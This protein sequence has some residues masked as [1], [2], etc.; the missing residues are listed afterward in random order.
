[1]IIITTLIYLSLS[2]LFLGVIDPLCFDFEAVCTDQ[3]DRARIPAANQIIQYGSFSQP[4]PYTDFPP[5]S[6]IFIA[7][8]RYLGSTDFTQTIYLQ[9]IAL[10][11]TGWLTKKILE[12]DLPKFGILGLVLVLFNPNL[13]SAAYTTYAET[14]Q[15]LFIVI[16]MYFLYRYCFD[17]S[18]KSA[19]A[20]GLFLAAATYVR[21]ITQYLVVLLPVIF[22]LIGLLCVDRINVS[23]T[24]VS[25]ILAT[26]VAVVCMLPWL[27]HMNSHGEG[28]RMYKQSSEPRYIVDI[29]RNLTPSMPGETN[30]LYKQEFYVDQEKR[31]STTVP[32]WESLS[33]HQKLNYQTKDGYLQLFN[34]VVSEPKVT[35]IAITKSTLRFFALGGTGKMFSLLYAN[36]V[37]QV[38]E[39][40]VQ[41][42]LK[43]SAHFEWRAQQESYFKSRPIYWPIK[44][45]FVGFAI[46][47][48]ILGLLGVI[49][50]IKRKRF[51]LLFVV[52]GVIVYVWATHFLVSHPRF[53]I[54][55]ESA[56]TVL[57]VYGIAY[58]NA[59]LKMFRTPKEKT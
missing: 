19:V 14:F 38:K 5:G 25:G 2:I 31:L 59:I 37:D 23:K 43:P 28:W 57:A 56:L 1:M 8:T 7:A 48:R 50:L 42:N 18:L 51:D 15:H 21:P 41:A 29:L 22:V 11:A 4:Q 49:Y 55:A 32:D 20:T 24:L 27:L 34:A 13:F 53:R 3:F 17:H 45:T 12:F 33:F 54:P 9:V 10:F 26:V 58:I 39:L 35:V 44:S 6:G 30:E 36:Q 46:T 47:M 52:S 16:S 40:H